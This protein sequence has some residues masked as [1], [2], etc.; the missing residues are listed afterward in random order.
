MN[1][2]IIAAVCKIHCMGKNNNKSIIFI[3]RAIPVHRQ[4]FAA[5][6]SWAVS[7][8]VS[9]S[10]KQIRAAVK[11]LLCSGKL[12]QVLKKLSKSSITA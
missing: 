11:E 7:L 12:L 4:P 3:P 5:L 8:L 6:D 2:R 1:E 10:G 9:R